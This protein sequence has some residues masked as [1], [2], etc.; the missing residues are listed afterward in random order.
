M[1][2]TPAESD[3]TTGLPFADCELTTTDSLLM[4]C[5]AD[6]VN[7]G[8]IRAGANPMPSKAGSWGNKS[9]YAVNTTPSPQPGIAPVGQWGVQFDG[10]DDRLQGASIT[11]PIPF[12]IYLV[13]A[14]TGDGGTWRDLFLCGGGAPALG[15]TNVVTWNPAYAKNLNGGIQST[16]N[17]NTG[18]PVVIGASIGAPTGSTR[19]LVLGVGSEIVTGST[20]TA[21]ANGDRIYIGN[22]TAGTTDKFAGSLFEIAAYTQAHSAATI[23]DNISRLSAWYRATL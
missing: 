4:R 16:V 20:T 10:V 22:G 6:R 19:P 8:D 5:S 18:K 1:T 3:N 15:L 9:L 14:S 7:S 12:T 11:F 21:A 2:R 13:I 23:K 17:P